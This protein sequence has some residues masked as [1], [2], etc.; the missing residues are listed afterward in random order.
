MSKLTRSGYVYLTS[1]KGPSTVGG[2]TSTR[3]RVDT[4]GAGA[5]EVM[6]PDWA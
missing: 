1:S 3:A 5:L 4:V 2:G 6:V